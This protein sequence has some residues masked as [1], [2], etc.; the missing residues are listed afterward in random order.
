[1]TTGCVPY[2]KAGL[3]WTPAATPRTIR[4]VALATQRTGLATGTVTEAVGR[5]RVAD[6]V[7]AAEVVQRATSTAVGVAVLLLT[8]WIAERSAD[9]GASQWQACLAGRVLMSAPAATS[10]VVTT[11]RVCCCSL[12]L[13]RA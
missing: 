2:A 11:T 8:Q 6:T 9:K 3:A 12:P 1:M 5:A 10:V 4:G 13:L 7:V